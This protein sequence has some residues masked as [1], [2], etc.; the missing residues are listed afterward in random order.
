[1]QFASALAVKSPQRNPMRVGIMVTGVLACAALAA[2]TGP[3]AWIPQA[4]DSCRQPDV[5]GEG[6]TWVVFLFYDKRLSV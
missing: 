3:A 4:A 5:G 1:M 2:G 6:A